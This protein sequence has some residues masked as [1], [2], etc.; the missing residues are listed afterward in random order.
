M[1]FANCS[2]AQSTPKITGT[3]EIQCLYLQMPI[4]LIRRIFLLQSHKSYLEKSI[5]ESEDNL[6]EMVLSKQMARTH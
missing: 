4:D 5:K 2:D 3:K 1:T 6:R